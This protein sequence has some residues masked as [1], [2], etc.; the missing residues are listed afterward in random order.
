MKKVDNRHHYLLVLD[1]ETTN[2]LM[3]N[4]FYD[5][6]FKV[7]DTKGR[8]Y[9]SYSFVNADIFCDEKELMQSAYYKEKIP[10]YWEDIKQ[11]TRTLATT[12]TIRKTLKEILAKYSI[13]E[14]SAHN[15]RFDYRALNLTYRWVTKSKYRFFLPYDVEMW[16]TLKMAR[17]IIL[18]MPSYQ[19]FCKKH[20]LFTPKGRLSATAENLYRFISKNAN[21]IESHTGLEDVEIESEILIYCLKKGCKNK[22]LF[23]NNS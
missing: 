10:N 16:D 21:F 20:N 5:L 14:I 4:L 9:E 17:E 22:K 7:I 18:P 1:T 8:T 6:G 19:A 11:G 3:D 13:T 15:A 2:T 23:E 12:Y